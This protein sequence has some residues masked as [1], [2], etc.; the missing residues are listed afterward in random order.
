M[1]SNTFTEETMS[2]MAT[3]AHVSPPDSRDWTLQAVGAAAPA[4]AVGCFIDLSWRTASMQ[5]QIGCCVGCTLE[6]IVAA[7]VHAVA[8]ANGLKDSDLSF[9]FV[10][11]ICKCLDGVEGQGTN[12]ALAAKVVRTYGVPLAA[13]CPNDVTLDHESF[14]YRRNLNNIPTEAF[15]GA[16][17][18]KSLADFTVPLTQAGIMQA[19]T[20]AKAN[21]GGVA[22]LRRISD[23]YWTASNGIVTWDAQKILP[24]RPPGV[25]VSGHAEFLYGYDF[26]PGT[27]RMRIYWLNHWSPQWAANGRGWEYA[28]E[29]LP[30]VVEIRVVVGKTP[31]V[32][33]FSY[34]WSD[35]MTRGAQGP[36]VVALQHV[37]KLEGLFPDGQAFTGYYGDITF[38]AVL[39]L[40]QKHAAQILAPLGLTHGTGAVGASTLAWL[41]ENY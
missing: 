25:I 28:D 11:A 3:G 12:I 36:D 34:G 10:Y 6:E 35:P 7:I 9:R 39:Q 18:R 37:L 2:G 19:I 38:N 27:G 26:E 30:F 20:Y 4:S 32:A 5:G 21:G 33:G 15:A 22:I 31:T 13:L 24:I 40:Q 16:K 23:S 14:V 17:G 1:N 8:A 41:N 29:W